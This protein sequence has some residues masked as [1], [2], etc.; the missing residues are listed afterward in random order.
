MAMC[1]IATCLTFTPTCSCRPGL[2][3]WQPLCCARATINGGRLPRRLVL[4][5]RAGVELRLLSD[6]SA[7]R[8]RVPFDCV[9]HVRHADSLPQVVT[10]GRRLP[11]ALKLHR[12]RRPLPL[13]LEHLK[14]RLSRAA[15]EKVIRQVGVGRFQARIERQACDLLWRH[16]EL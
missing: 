1:R 16:N 14:P 6:R 10:L 11:L 2:T 13:F 3:A 7:C 8:R 15:R 12:I 9:C 4:G 5:R